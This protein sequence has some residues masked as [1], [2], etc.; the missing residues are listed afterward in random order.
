MPASQG[1]DDDSP[2]NINR[3][4]GE[5]GEGGALRTKGLWFPTFV[6]FT[7]TRGGGV[8]KTVKE[9]QTIYIRSMSE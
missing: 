7:G 4:A 6:Y 3:M 5:E 1:L 2:N 8:A 9:R